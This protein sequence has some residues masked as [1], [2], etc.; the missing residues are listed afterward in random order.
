M[1][2]DPLSAAKEAFALIQ[3]VER[4][5]RTAFDDS[6]RFGRLGEQWP[7]AIRRQREADRRPCLTFN[8]MNAFTRLVV[9]DARQNKPQIQVHPVDSNADPETAD[10]INGLIR[11]IESTSNADVAYDTAMENAAAGGIG[12]ITVSTE[13]ADD[14]GFD[15]DLRIN[16][17]TDPLAIYG[18][19]FDMSADSANWNSAFETEWVAI[20]DFEARF[21]K[22]DVVD[23]DAFRS[24]GQNWFDHDGKRVLIAKHW[25]RTE[26][27]RDIVAVRFADGVE[28]M[29]AQVYG[30]NKA[31]FDSLDAQ[32][33]AEREVRS[34][35]V[36]W[37]L[38]SGA[39]ILADGDWGGRYIPIVP[40][41]G[42]VVNLGGKR[43]LRSLIWDAMDAQRM[44]NFHRSSAVEAIAL[45]PK[46]PFIGPK[47]AFETDQ[48]KWD[49]A[50]TE[51]HAYI[52][53]DGQIPPQ[54][55]PFVGVPAAQMQ[56]AVNA[57]EDMK[58]IIGIHD[59]GRG[60]ESNDTSGVMVLARQRK[61][62]IA[63]FHFTD[64]LAR[65][66]RHT[67]RILIDLIPSVYSGPRMLRVLGLDGKP[68]T[69]QVGPPG[70]PPQPIPA[71]QGAPGAAPPPVAPSV[72]APGQPD[73]A[74]LARVYDLTAG[75]YDLTVESGPSFTTQREEEA[76]Q[77]LA[78]VQADPQLA[79]PLAPIIAKNLDWHGA[80]D[81]AK[82]VEG[83]QQANAAKGQ[84]QQDPLA[85][86][87]A[88]SD[89][90]LGQAKMQLDVQK[91]QVDAQARAA[92]MQ[93]DQQRFAFEQRAH[94]D[95][96]DLER[97]K[98]EIEAEKVRQDAL[99]REHARQI[100]LME[101]HA[102][103][104]QDRRQG[105]QQHVAAMTGIHERHATAVQ[106]TGMRIGADLAIQAS[107]QRDTALEQDGHPDPKALETI[108]SDDR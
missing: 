4:D 56:E 62:D 44:Y 9:N 96:T 95:K 40:V 35:K 36:R 3:D 75:K 103:I 83:V 97:R 88:Q 89:M 31:F 48:Y 21:P 20:K 16:A 27:A 72:P 61:S 30:E 34:H 13:Y 22:A 1:A 60:A 69:V 64:N 23:W 108:S 93:M 90:Q 98:L 79:A 12:Y 54:R 84:P 52:E 99:D 46:T 25:R 10:I 28:T 39:E 53:Y 70:T 6:V 101:T 87:R 50:N 7:D 26:H 14:D 51:S 38:M 100:K 85:M 78:L 73:P 67:G 81:V 59:P 77:M 71:Q 76:A 104:A 106:T 94:Q 19:P 92:D 102:H 47:G 5:N 43:H 8:M 11:N 91:A 41:Y 17:V 80:E 45:Q 2:D 29:D 82:A 58:S 24:V 63:N 18:D 66:I 107:E 37:A 55:Q 49:T 105:D 33:I 42:D 68:A 32:V 15:V 74:T 57:S 65:A 86:A